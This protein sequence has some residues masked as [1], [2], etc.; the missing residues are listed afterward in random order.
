MGVDGKL[1]RLWWQGWVFGI[2]GAREGRVESRLDSTRDL[3][4][5]MEEGVADQK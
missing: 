3:Q 2:W 1:G 5:G 4:K